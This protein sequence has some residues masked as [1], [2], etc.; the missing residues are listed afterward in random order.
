MVEIGQDAF[1]FNQNDA[2]LV[3]VCKLEG[4]G[5]DA[6]NFDGLAMAGE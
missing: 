1:G 2:F 5:Q 4:R 3:L 6:M